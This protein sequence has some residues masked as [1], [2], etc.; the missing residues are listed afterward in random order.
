[1]SNAGN[2]GLRTPAIDSI[3]RQGV[4]FDRAY[5]NNPICVPSR[6]S[7]ITAQMS[8]RTTVTF[9]ADKH[10]IAV[11]PMSRLFKAAGYDTGFVG[12]W[13]IPHPA[14]D[15]DWHGFDYVR[16]ARANRLDPDLPGACAE[17]L[18]RKREKPFF[19]VASFVDPHDICEWARME[20]GIKDEFKTAPFRLR[21]LRPM[22]AAAGQF[23]HPRRGARGDPA[24]GPGRAHH[25]SRGP[26]AGRQLAAIPLGLLSADRVGR[27]PNRSDS[28]DAAGQWAG[29]AHRRGFR[30]RPWR[31][32]GRPS[33]GPKDHLL[34]GGGRHSVHR[35]PAPLRPGR[36]A[37]CIQSREHESGFFSDRLRLRRNRPPPGLPG[38]SVRPLVEG[39]P[40]ASGHD[41]II[42]QN[43]LAPEDRSGGIYGRMV[44]TGRHKYVRFSAGRYREQF[45]DLALDPGEMNN[46]TEDP[47]HQE[48]L[49]RHRAILDRW[50]E[51]EGDPFPHPICAE[52]VRPAAGGT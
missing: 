22:P 25:L 16:H 30:E 51:R 17:F 35:P 6:T 15:L 42:G 20:S 49:V 27:C 19:L 21:R 44:R 7:W 3:A 39:K 34:R 13:H 11:P 1:M 29:R 26:L 36:T 52:D 31:R 48:E 37:G 24:I 40:G 5:S 9:N 32:D 28:A 33:L 43:D 41:Y 46:L 18:Q 8:H 45:F 47:A 38:R 14:S 50:M 2:T 4:V 10:G 12:K 23:C